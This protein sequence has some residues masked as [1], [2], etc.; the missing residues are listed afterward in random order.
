M[1]CG[2]KDFGMSGGDRQLYCTACILRGLKP[3]FRWMV[4]VRC[5]STCILVRTCELLGDVIDRD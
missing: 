2:R 3:E 1:R 4:L 5:V